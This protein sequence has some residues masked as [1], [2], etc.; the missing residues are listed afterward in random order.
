[1]VAAFTAALAM[2]SVMAQSPSPRGKVTNA[3]FQ[4]VGVRLYDPGDKIIRMFGSPNEI[5]AINFGGSGSAGPGGATGGG[6]GGTS[7]NGS[8]AGAALARE[9]VLPGLIGDPFNTGRLNQF[10]P[11][12]PGGDPAQGGTSG[13]GAASAGDGAAGGGATGGAAS[14]RTIFT[15]WVYKRGTSRY[16][17]VFDKFNKVIQIE[18]LGFSDKKVKTRKGVA[19]GTEFGA[20]I[21]LYGAPDGYEVGGQNIVVRYLVNKRVAFRLSRL[22][23]DGKHK[24]TG[25]VVA[26]GKQ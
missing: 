7:A 21:K 8:G 2:N 14:A 13:R 5:M 1:M 11:D 16:A 15:R 10:S 3:E 20:L 9:D 4:L 12:E 24:V 22:T 19:F 23:K 18:A 26:A 6:G 17:F 25:I